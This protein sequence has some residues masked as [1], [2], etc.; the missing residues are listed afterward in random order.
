MQQLLQSYFLFSYCY[1]IEG[2]TIGGIRKKLYISN[3][4]PGV[5]ELRPCFWD[6]AILITNIFRSSD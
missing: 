2:L 6:A 1:E 3:D 5:Q 4:F